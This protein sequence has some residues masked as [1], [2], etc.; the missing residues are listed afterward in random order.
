MV[1]SQALL[2]RQQELDLLRNL[3][4]DVGSSGGRVVLVRGEA[5]I[6]KSSLVREF[7]TAS[8]D[9]THVL[10]G[11]CD[12][13]VTPQPLGPFWDIARAETSLA[14][15][16]AEANRR[17]LFEAVMDLLSRPL[18]PTILVLEDTHWADEATLD[19]V[20]YLGRRIEQANG[21]LV[22]TYRDG[23]VDFDHPLRAVIGGLPPA[24]V[25][26]IQLGGLSPSA[27]ASMLVGSDLDVDEVN[28]ATDGNPFLVT[29]LASAGAV[30]VPTSVQDSVMTRMGK[31]SS[32]ARQLLKLLSVIPERISR[33]E[34]LQI[35]D[36][37]DAGLDEIER[38]HLLKTGDEFVG[39][40]HDLIRRAVEASLATSERAALNGTVLAAL[41]IDT[42]P[43]R[44]VHHASEA[45]D[46]DRLVELAPKAAESAL[47]LGSHREARDHFRRLAG[48]LK[49][50]DPNLTGAILDR[51]AVEE[52]LQGDYDSA[53]R[54]NELSVFHYRAT[55]DRKGE[56]AA[57][58]DA[59]F[60]RQRVGQRSTA[61]R[62]ARQAVDVL[63][64]NAAG[65]DLARALEVNAYLAMMASDFT[66]TLD[67][68]ER[69]LAAA[70]PDGDERIIIRSLNHRGVALNMLKYPDGSV[71]LEE[72]LRRAEAIDD[73]DEV[74]RANSN[75]AGTAIDAR[76]LSTA[77][78]LIQRTIG[79][80]NV[81]EQTSSIPYSIAMHARILDLQ[82]RWTEAENLARGDLEYQHLAEMAAAPVYGAIDAR[83]GR[84]TAQAAV[85]RAWEMAV[86]MDEYQRLA[87]AASVFAEYSW[88][89]GSTDFPVHDIRKVME[90]GLELD[91]EWTAGSI[92][93]WLW[94]LG[95][96]DEAPEGIAE[97]YRLT[98]GGEPM[99]A[100]EQ[101]AEVGCPY[102]R[103]IALSHGDQSAQ[104]EALEELDQLGADAVAAKLR[105]ELR[106]RG[107]SVPRRKSRKP[108]DD[109]S[110][111]TPR[112]AEVLSLL[113]E[114]RSNADIANQLFLSSRTVEHHVAAVMSKFDASSRNEA[115]EKAVEQGLL[116][117]VS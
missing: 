29:E 77:A 40:R 13:L 107:V 50:I 93:L 57:L 78:Y 100:A 16:L 48:H 30:V 32:E 25:L 90:T 94:K 69:T 61:E 54:V 36:G 17:G 75:R 67:L 92:A 23:E 26:R 89:S 43:A 116:T 106:G 6:G 59:A 58:A 38:G 112:Q 81:N 91:S 3:L 28:A 31:L 66:T 115:V 47:A 18:R 65:R 71:S 68:V 97:P 62:F 82:G 41:P 42:D 22:L 64:P 37:A 117:A 102:E 109:S 96:L 4:A 20:K 95:E 63:G 1:G 84:N 45:G 12:D 24:S 83:R 52:R 19:A 5:G 35:A 34:I 85:M 114:H 60:Y 101:W 80:G 76:D 98:I 104:L 56:S 55:G 70:G 105:Q 86:A 79:Q 110:E 9:E 111:L 73:V 44:L 108:G 2:E 74:M 27:V 11:W 46:F 33:D 99:A 8:S 14:D 113:A 39:F 51:W 72:A 103:A 53:I 15:P 10:V 21:L 88:I 7:L 49:R 87:P